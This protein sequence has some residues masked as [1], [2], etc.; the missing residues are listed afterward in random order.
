MS[1]MVLAREKVHAEPSAPAPAPEVQLPKS[2]LVI[3]KPLRSGQ[4][5]YARGRDAVVL[6]RLLGEAG[7]TP[8]RVPDLAD[9]SG[10]LVEGRRR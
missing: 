9:V 2:A 10:E 5:V 3:D 4:Q 6:A 1:E 7:R 8:T